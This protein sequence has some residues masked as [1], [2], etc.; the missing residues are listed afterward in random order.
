MTF[1]HCRGKREKFDFPTH[2]E[3][4]EQRKTNSVLTFISPFS[5]T[6]V[7]A[8]SPLPHPPIKTTTVRHTVE[9]SA[10]YFLLCFLRLDRVTRESEACSNLLLCSSA[11]CLVLH[12]RLCSV[13]GII[14]ALV[15]I[16]YQRSLI[17][18]QVIALCATMTAN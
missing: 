16:S 17:P 5:F 12:I 4:K 13:Y 3:D 2:S 1:C 8:R 15:V 7:A 10:S 9:L 14:K 18:F 6:A 11:Q